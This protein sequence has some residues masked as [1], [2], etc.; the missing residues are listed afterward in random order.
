MSLS[1]YQASIPAFLRALGVLHTLLEKAQAHAEEHGIVPETLLGAR[2][3]DD[4]LPLSAQVQRASDASKLAVERLSG[5]AS[6]KFADDETSFQQLEQRIA[7]TVAYLNSVTP[8]DLEQGATREVKLSFGAFQAEFN[9]AD[10]LLSF[11]LP[12]FYFHIVTAYDI[13]RNQGVAVGK[14]DYLGHFG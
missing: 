12:N 2:L 11:A 6:P 8:A 1:M 14:R 9:G 13:L 10:Y 3:A 7:A 4:M 5:I